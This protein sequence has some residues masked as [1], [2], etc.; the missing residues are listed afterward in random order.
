MP[1]KPLTDRSDPTLRAAG[2]GWFLT[3][4]GCLTASAEFGAAPQGI[5]LSFY[6]RPQ[7]SKDGA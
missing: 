1:R 6:K 2:V 3:H 5:A 4:P 7:L